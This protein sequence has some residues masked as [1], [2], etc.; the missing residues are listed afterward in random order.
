MHSDKLPESYSVNFGLFSGYTV[1]C[2]SNVA[3][4]YCLA[5]S[6]LVHPSPS[7]GSEPLPSD[8]KT[9]L[10]VLAKNG[11]LLRCHS[12]SWWLGAHN[13]LELKPFFWIRRCYASPIDSSGMGEGDS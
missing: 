4:Y 8:P 5:S 1:D 10:N 12:M 13:S 9:I 2:M 11:A 6:S 3:G 7:A